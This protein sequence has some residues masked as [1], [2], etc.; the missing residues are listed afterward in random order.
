MDCLAVPTITH[1]TFARLSVGSAG[2]QVGAD[3]LYA[4]PSR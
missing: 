1:S 2:R 4:R 3:A